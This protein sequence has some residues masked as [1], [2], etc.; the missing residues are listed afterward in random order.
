VAG[1]G[2]RVTTTAGGASAA[3][4]P[5]TPSSEPALAPIDISGRWAMF[6]FED[7]VGIQVTEDA[8]ALTGRGCASGTPPGD[9]PRLSEQ[10][11][12]DVQGTVKANRAYFDFT[13]LDADYIADTTVS[14]DGQ[15]MTGR[16]HGAENW[17]SYP[18]AWLRVPDGAPGL[19]HSSSLNNPV[20][21]GSYDL[22][23]LQATPGATEYVTEHVYSLS[24]INGRLISDLG[25]F[26]YSE[27]ASP[28]AL[29]SVAVGP[30]PMTE[31]A[32]AVSMVLE[33]TD[34]QISQVVANTGSGHVYVFVA[35]PTPVPP[36]SP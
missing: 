32:L 22:H 6:H 8:G 31:P 3:G 9:A 15:R 12:G 11:C 36:P 10:Y 18:T 35:T 28:D 19:L 4:A 24:Y 26:W 29:G 2:T 34:T 21:A 13:F 23:L 30:V 33:V 7:P 1:G 5:D 25:A 27:I 16:F 17:L 20:G 14:V